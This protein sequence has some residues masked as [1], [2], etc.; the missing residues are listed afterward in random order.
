M[1]THKKILT[2]TL[3]ALLIAVGIVIPMISP[4]KIQIGPMS[5]TLASHVAIMVA[6]FISP[7]VSI[8]VALGTTLGF[9]LAGFPDVVVLRAL[10]H[11]IWAAF[12]G[13]YIMKH[14][15]LFQSPIKT[16]GFN[17]AI[18]VIHALGEMIVVVP[19]YYGAGMDIQAF[20]YMVFGL[21]GL[22]TIVHSSV[23]FIISLVV[24]KA[25]SQ[26]TSISDVSN[27]KKVYL[28]KNA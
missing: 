2:M 12:G 18:A 25:L 20:C 17:L 9:F 13:Y 1:N 3:S 7:Q 6:L 19:F 23:D 27:V 24:W 15:D 28:I 5:F 11:V 22:G 14:S 10:S 4:I 26:N 21:V 16:L 8:A